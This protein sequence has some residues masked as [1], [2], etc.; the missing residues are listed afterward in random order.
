MVD[1]DGSYLFKK[2]ESL[3][4]PTDSSQIV[5]KPPITGWVTVEDPNCENAKHIPIVTH[6]TFFVTKK[7]HYNFNFVFPGLLYTY[8]ADSSGVSGRGEAFRSLQRGFIHWSSGRL[9]KL[10]INYRHPQFCH[11]QCQM[12]PS[13]KQGSYRV[14]ILLGRVVE[15]ASILSATCECAAGL[16]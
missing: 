1:V 15:F 6:G 13:M 2:Q 7:D 8:L 4:G 10:E 16:V 9:N 5:P 11:V 14:Y 3:P 12:T